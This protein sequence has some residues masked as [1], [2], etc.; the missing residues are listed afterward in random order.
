MRVTLT[1]SIPVETAT[2][3]K[4]K[5]Q[6]QVITLSKFISNI[7]A[8]YIKINESQNVKNKPAWHEMG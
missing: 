6:H 3:L 8:D 2:A 7:L 1:I 5:A 4:I